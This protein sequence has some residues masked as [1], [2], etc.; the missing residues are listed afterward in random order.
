MTCEITN[1]STTEPIKHALKPYITKLKRIDTYEF[2]K[3]EY[4]RVFING[5]IQGFVKDPVELMKDL[6]LKRSTCNISVYKSFDFDVMKQ[7]INIYTDEGRCIESL[8]KV[9]DDSLLISNYTDK[10]KDISWNI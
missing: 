7:N 3:S 8:L 4:C 10:L 1:Y 5:E 6:R 9:K 2:N